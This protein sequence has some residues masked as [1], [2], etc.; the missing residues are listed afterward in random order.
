MYP[1]GLLKK[2][3]AGNLQQ[4]PVGSKMSFPGYRYFDTDF[5]YARI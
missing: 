2:H 1:F 5:F 3:L 4:I